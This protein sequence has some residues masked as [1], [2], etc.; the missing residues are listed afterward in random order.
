MA[1]PVVSAKLCAREDA[2]GDCIVSYKQGESMIEVSNLEQV[3]KAFWGPLTASHWPSP[4]AT[5]NRCDGERRP[6]RRAFTRIQHQLGHD[7][8]IDF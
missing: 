4:H 7:G 6:G 3:L 5:E 2:E 8:L 1:R